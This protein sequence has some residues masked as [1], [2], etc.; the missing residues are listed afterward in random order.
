MVVADVSRG[1]GKDYSA[2][3]VIDTETNVQVL[4]IKDKLALKNMDIY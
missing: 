1:D 4:N 3:H 2:F